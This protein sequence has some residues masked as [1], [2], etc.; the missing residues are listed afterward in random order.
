MGKIGEKE[1]LS[2]LEK[3]AVDSSVDLHW[4]AFNPNNKQDSIL[5]V[6]GG[7]GNHSQ[8]FKAWLQMYPEYTASFGWLS[9]DQRGCGL[10]KE[11][12]ELSHDNNVDDLQI[13]IRQ[14]EASGHNISAVMGHSYGATLVYESFIKNKDIDKKLIL[15][16]RSPDLLTPANRNMM[17]DL[18]LLKLFQEDAY[19][20]LEMDLQ[21][22]FDLPSNE[23]WEKKQKIRSELKHT[24]KR[25]LFYWANLSVKDKYE[26][27]KELVNIDEDQSVFRDVAGTMNDPNN[28]RPH[29]DIKKLTQ[30]ALHILG[31]YDFLMGGDYFK[32]SSCSSYIAESFMF[33]GHYPHLEEPGKFILSINKFLES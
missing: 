12:Y 28:P 6:H 8:Y 3:Q 2:V 24:D 19:K 22:L 29:F 1:V 16:G 14:I 15:V 4:W 33:S 26:K 27:I 23:L 31:Y 10:S 9:Y 13:M 25:S 7:P 11:R 30:P 20:K 21:S 18:L 17:I 32:Q 5:F